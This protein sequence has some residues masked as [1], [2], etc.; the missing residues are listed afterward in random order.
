MVLKCLQLENTRLNL[1]PTEGQLFRRIFR[2]N[3]F[4]IAF[5]DII[6]QKDFKQRF[7]CFVFGICVGAR[8]LSITINCLENN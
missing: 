8:K 2:I 3:L 6:F 4:Q 5:I 1:M 7:L